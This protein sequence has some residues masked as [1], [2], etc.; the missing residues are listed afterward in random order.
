MTWQLDATL[1][2]LEEEVRKENDASYRYAVGLIQR[3]L[4]RMGFS[5][6]FTPS[7]QVQIQH[8]L[9]TWDQLTKE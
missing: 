8:I 3:L 6:Q 7:Q 2:E 1:K 4:T 9:G 5:N